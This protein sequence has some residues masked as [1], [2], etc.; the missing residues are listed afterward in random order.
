MAGLG[1]PRVHHR[2]IG[3]T[4]E[5]ARLLAA[6]G[7]PHGTLVTAAE[8]TA[9]HGR[10]GREWWAPPGDSLL[11]SLV[12][13]WPNGLPSAPELLPLL[14]G[15]AVCEVVGSQARLKWPNDVVVE[16][17]HDATASSSA[18]ALA[19]LGGILVEGRPQAGWAVVGIGLNVAVVADDVPDRLRNV[20]ATLDRAREDIEPLLEMLLDAL[21]RR[22]GSPAANTL[23]AFRERDVLLGRTVAWQ[24]PSRG[25]GAAAAHRQGRAS[26]IDGTGRLVVSFDDGTR[27]TLDAGEVHLV[28]T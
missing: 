22:L 2:R 1:N 9:G 6:A 19:K 5:H 23:D 28:E 13:R 27:R 16:R 3:S 20:V 14:A 8:Q 21:E 11:M 12:L 25:D 18:P 24:L 26:G 7:A 17:G 15:V 10:Q 4:N